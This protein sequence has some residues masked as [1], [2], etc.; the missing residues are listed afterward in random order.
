MT[1][2]LSREQFRAL[3]VGS[4]ERFGKMRNKFN[5]KRTAAPDG[6]RTYDSKREAE[7]CEQLRMLE[8]AGEIHDLTLQPRYQLHVNGTLIGAYVA[9]ARYID[10]GG[11]LHVI[12]IKSKA[13][14]TPLFRWKR[15]HFEAEYLIKL[16]I[17]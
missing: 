7:V 2:V 14:M 5:A 16:E 11:R 3:N 15:K 12:D 13:T 1:T 10:K 8:R 6:S 17:P 9:D 4:P